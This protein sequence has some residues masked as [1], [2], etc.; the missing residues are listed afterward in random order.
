MDEVS[1]QDTKKDSSDLILE[2]KE[3][4]DQLA[5]SVTTGLKSQTDLIKDSTDQVLVALED[6]KTTKE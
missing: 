6:F 2:V 5:I 1:N 3:S 4:L